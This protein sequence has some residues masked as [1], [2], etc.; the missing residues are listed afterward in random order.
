MVVKTFGRRPTWSFA[1][2]PG[3]QGRLL[4]NP[5][6]TCMQL[7][8]LGDIRHHG[9]P[10]HWLE[11]E[12]TWPTGGFQGPPW[13]VLCKSSA[14]SLG[15]GHKRNGKGGRSPP[16]HAWLSSSLW[17]KGGRTLLGHPALP[18]ASHRGRTHKSALLV[19]RNCLSR[20]SCP[21]LW[22]GVLALWGLEGGN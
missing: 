4:A 16:G 20:R 12:G 5:G 3:R 22:L 9:T 11:S 1:A 10:C 21:T 19:L 15:Q 18:L 2:Q 8:D 7:R 17:P 14:A 6:S 13:S